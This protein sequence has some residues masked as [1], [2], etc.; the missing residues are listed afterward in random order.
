RSGWGAP[1]PAGG[2][3]N[4]IDIHAKDGTRFIACCPGIILAFF[5]PREDSK[6]VHLMYNSEFVVTYG[7]E[8]TKEIVVTRGQ[9][10]N[11]GDTIGYLGYSPPPD[12]GGHIHFG[13]MKNNKFICP[14]PYL[15]EDVR[16]KFNEIYQKHPRPGNYPKNICNCP[17]HQKFFD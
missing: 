6:D 7:F 12:C 8:P 14:I 11:V 15:R 17:E 13:L 3:H 2:I 4:G 10:V 5:T 9:N 1:G 16:K